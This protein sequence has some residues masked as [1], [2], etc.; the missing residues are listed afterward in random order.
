MRHQEP[1]KEEAEKRGRKSKKLR[2]GSRQR[3]GR[4]GRKEGGRKGWG[5]RQERG[6]RKYRGRMST[7]PS[8]LTII[9]CTI[10]YNYCVTFGVSTSKK[11]D[12]F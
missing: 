8:Q 5:G 1:T 12:F 9:N 2:A 6:Q 3:D 4:E 10:I 11:T 7:E